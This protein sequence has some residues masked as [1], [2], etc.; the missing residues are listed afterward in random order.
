MPP[1]PRPDFLRHR[2]G[3]ALWLDLTAGF[4]EMIGLV[5][6]HGLLPVQVAVNAPLAIA[7]WSQTGQDFVART[8]AI[9][10]FILVTALASRA[11]S[12]AGHGIRL[13]SGHLLFFQCLLLMG[14][15][16]VGVLLGPFP[17]SDAP[18]AVAAG[19]LLVSAMALQGVGAAWLWR[20]RLSL[21]ST[22]DLARLSIRMG[23]GVCRGRDVSPQLMRLGAFIVG[24]GVAA[25]VF[26]IAGFWSLGLAAAGSLVTLFHFVPFDF[27]RA[28]ADV[29]RR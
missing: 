11:L 29:G 20:E 7:A 26:P 6:L 1:P 9:P 15:M 5:G 17:R 4:V 25:L 8:L 14:A 23:R 22:F 24:A 13:A 19:L 16:A 28:F 2:F 21:V 27:A 12:R 10:V 3:A 18:A